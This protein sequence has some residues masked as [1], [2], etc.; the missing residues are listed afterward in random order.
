MS[1]QDCLGKPGKNIPRGGHFFRNLSPA[2]RLYYMV[3]S[4]HRRESAS[5]CPACLRSAPCQ[6]WGRYF[7]RMRLPGLSPSPA[8]QAMRLASAEEGRA[9]CS[10]FVMHTFSCT[11][12]HLLLRFLSLQGHASAISE[13]ISSLNLSLLDSKGLGCHPALSRIASARS[14]T[15]STARTYPAR[16]KDWAISS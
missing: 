9:L 7:C 3:G 10:A 5:L 14:A 8:G 13:R 6:G 11:D 1:K 16:A 4:A 12:S 15:S 2:A